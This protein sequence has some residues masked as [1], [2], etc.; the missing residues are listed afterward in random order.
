MLLI[1]P[2][3]VLLPSF[4][5]QCADSVLLSQS[6]SEHL[7]AAGAFTLAGETAYVAQWNFKN[8]TWATLGSPADVPGPAT[9]LSTDSNN[10]SKIWLAGTS[11]TDVPYL[12][13]WN[14]TT[15]ADVNDGVLVS[16]SGVQQLVFVPLSTNHRA[17][18]LIE[19]DR[20]LLVSGDLTINSTSISS[21]LF[22]GETWYPYLVSSTA[23]GSAGVI[24]QLFYS[25]TNFS[26]SKGTLVLPRAG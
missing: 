25:I 9:A 14:G 13:F 12:L 4:L 19:K 6:K 20:M 24:S 10:E 8:Q 18:A 22:D 1:S 15:W 16:G 7:V 2:G 26:L 21:A 11:T 17:E 3:C 23:T 5:W